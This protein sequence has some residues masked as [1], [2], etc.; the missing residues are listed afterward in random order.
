MFASRPGSFRVKVNRNLNCVHGT[1]YET[2]VRSSL[3]S[4][5]RVFA[6]NAGGKCC[7]A[8]FTI[9]TNFVIRGEG[10]GASFKNEQLAFPTFEIIVQVKVS[11]LIIMNLLFFFFFVR[12]FMMV[13]CSSE[14][15]TSAFWHRGAF[16]DKGMEI[17]A[18]WKFYLKKR[19]L[20]W[21]YSI[22]LAWPWRAV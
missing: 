21:Y 2:L 10:G 9:E 22:L 15:F 18:R 3:A 1:S 12:M 13:I 19:G 20:L 6:L 5:D 7:S 17:W 8:K 4:F 14:Y 16:S 11:F